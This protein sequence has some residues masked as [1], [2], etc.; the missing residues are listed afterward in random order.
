MIE[1]DN[2]QE[3][4]SKAFENQT[5][6]VRPDLWAGVQAKMAAAGVAS[7][8]TIATKGL[9]ALTKWII[10]SAAVGTVGVVTT[11]IALNSG[12]ESTNKMTDAPKEISQ[13]ISVSSP[14]E[15]SKKTESATTDKK[16]DTYTAKQLETN[17]TGP[18]EDIPQEMNPFSKEYKKNEERVIGSD[19]SSES[20]I[21]D[22]GKTAEKVTP[23]DK[24]KNELVD[25]TESKKAPVDKK[26][27]SKEIT[28][29]VKHPED[30][31]EPVF[32]KLDESKVTKFP[33]VFTPNGDRDNDTYF[34][35]VE[36]IDDFQLLIIDQNNREM[37]KTNNPRDEWNGMNMAGE[38]APSGSYAAI[39][40]GK[41]QNGK[42]FR[43]I[44]LFE[45]R[46]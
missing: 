37:F 6:S 10:G 31:K 42:S 45:L 25:K 16:Q 36:N 44:Q 9:S 12:E 40:T 2:I 13:N 21:Q 3:L 18:F 15:E 34:V 23:T 43:E 14:E 39:V 41:Q 11:V 46:R 30:T 8:A 4:F 38:V 5:T 32:V 24:E 28:S 7:T 35:T 19:H 33:N 29:L 27:V 17:S 1:K 20:I 26:V 22:K